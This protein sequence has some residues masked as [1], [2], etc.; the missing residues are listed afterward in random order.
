MIETKSWCA[1]QRL[2]GARSADGRA[3]GHAGIRAVAGEGRRPCEAS[4]L[5][6]WSGS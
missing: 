2:V 4:S 6:A 5:C 1:W 3:L